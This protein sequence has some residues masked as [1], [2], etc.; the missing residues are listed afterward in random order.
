MR[1]NEQR[2]IERMKAERMNEDAMR[3]ECGMVD[4]G[5]PL[6]TGPSVCVL[7]KLPPH[8]KGPHKP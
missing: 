3:G 7:I 2:M 5:T 1:A 4:T 6:P 8:P